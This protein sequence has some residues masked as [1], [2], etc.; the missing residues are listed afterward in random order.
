M[1]FD[2]LVRD[3]YLPAGT[4]L[5]L[6][7]ARAAVTRLCRTAG[8]DDLRTLLDNDVITDDT[9]TGPDGS[10][11]ALTARA[12]G[13]RTA[14]EQQ[15]HRLLQAFASSLRRR[16]VARFRFDHD[17]GTGVD[18]YLTGGCSWGDSPTDAYDSWDIVYDT[19]RLPDGWADQ[20]GAACGLLHP[21]GLGPATLTVAFH[22]W[23][24]PV[25]EARNG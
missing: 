22:A 6:A 16:D 12:D 21:R 4:T 7:A 10:D 8:L 25:A 20:I 13:L 24:V 17:T 9:L 19:D 18:A 14:A 2:M 3:L 23:A 11:R 5:D 15:L 1:G